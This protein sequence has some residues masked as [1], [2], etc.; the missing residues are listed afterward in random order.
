MNRRW[1]TAPCQQ[2]PTMLDNPYE[3]VINLLYY[4]PNLSLHFTLQV[5]NGHEMTIAKVEA[6]HEC[7]VYLG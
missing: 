4:V 6:R 3:V 7:S 5:M 1:Q 2:R